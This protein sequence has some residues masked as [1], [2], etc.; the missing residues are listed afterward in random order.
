[1]IT[2]DRGVDSTRYADSAGACGAGTTREAVH[3]EIKW[4][5]LQG[6]VRR[7]GRSLEFL[8]IPDR[9]R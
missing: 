4:R 9:T 3:R 7:R 1:L 2:P 5:A 6:L 8:D